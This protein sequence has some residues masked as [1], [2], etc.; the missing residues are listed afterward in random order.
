MSMA[1][2]RPQGGEESGSCGH[3]W[4]GG[5]GQKLDSLVSVINGWL[6]SK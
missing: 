3:M 4:T 6:N 2:G 5:G 1:C